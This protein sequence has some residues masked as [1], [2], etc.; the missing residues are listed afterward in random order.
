VLL[1]RG[2]VQIALGSHWQGFLVARI[3]PFC[4]STRRYRAIKH[5]IRFF[6]PTLLYS[7]IRNVVEY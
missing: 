2:P 3:T 4:A 6:V 5:P 7:L 1:S